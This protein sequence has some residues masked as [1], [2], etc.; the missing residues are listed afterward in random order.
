M[1]WWL[2]FVGFVSKQT[3]KF[4]IPKSNAIGVSDIYIGNTDNNKDNKKQKPT[5]NNR[6]SLEKIIKSNNKNKTFTYGKGEDGRFIRNDTKIDDDFMLLNISKFI[7][8]M[9]LL[10][11]LES[12]H[13]GI[14]EKKNAIRKYEHD[15]NDSQYI[16]KLKSGGLLKDWEYQ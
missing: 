7:N 13:V 8:Q 12:E 3:S 15:N 6:S 2:F 10:T 11:L 14:E 4:Y 16:V 5:I 9:N 1:I